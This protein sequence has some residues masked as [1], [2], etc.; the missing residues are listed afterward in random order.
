VKGRWRCIN[1]SK[2]RAWKRSRPPGASCGVCF[3][4][5]KWDRLPACQPRTGKMPVPL[6][7]VHGKVAG[8]A[9][10]ISGNRAGKLRARH[11]AL[12]PRHFPGM[13]WCYRN[14][15][16]PF[17]FS[18][19]S[20]EIHNRTLKALGWMSRHEVFCD[21]LASFYRTPGL[22]VELFGLRFPNPVGLAGGMDKHAEAVPIW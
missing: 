11:P 19:D 3:G 18:L 13:S 10:L 16:R 17:L 22:P 1:N 6:S 4:I 14:F 9:E 12:D 2:R 21:A 5:E 15:V 20:E 8:F 7:E